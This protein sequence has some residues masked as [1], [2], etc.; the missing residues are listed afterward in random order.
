MI[1]NSKTLTFLLLLS[2]L[3]LSPVNPFAAAQ[4]TAQSAT[5]MPQAVTGGLLDLNYT[6]DNRPDTRAYSGKK[7]YVGMSF[8][9]DLGNEQ[10]VI[11]VSQDHGRWPTHHPGAY[12]VE[13]ARNEDGPWMLAFEGAGQRGDSRAK[14][15][16][17]RAR[18]IRVT[19]TSNRTPYNEEWSI[20]ELRGGIDPG[21][22]AREIP[23]PPGRN[24]DRNPDPVTPPSRVRELGNTRDAFDN[25]A[26][27]YASSGTGDYVG[28]V[29]NFDLG[30][31][32]ELSRVVQIHGERRDDFPAE[33]KIEVSRAKDESR[34]REVF[35]GAGSLRRTVATFEPVVTRYVRL[36]ALRKRD[37]GNWWS[38]AELRTNR[39]RDVVD[40][41]EDDG[42]VARQI[43]SIT[44]NGIG[45]IVAVLDDN[46]T[47]RATTTSPRYEGSWINIDLGGS[48]TVSRIVQVHEP[49]EGAFPGRYKVEVSEDGNR[50]R[51]A[52]EGAG[53]PG[54]SIAEFAPLRARYIR[55]VAIDNRNNR[56][57]WTLYKLK[58]RG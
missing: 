32:Y 8:T 17:I 45:N 26:N 21:Q 40:R 57:L 43:R 52:F 39:D 48:Y 2:G 20:A 5:V 13:V 31:E 53:Q 47:S 18:F 27:S 46:N 28:M 7:D 37:T 10:N 56:Q 3:F 25:N 14:F 44:A 58:V 24:P 49:D 23:R 38:I 15:P 12:R 16:A 19:A 50:W 35:R 9:I 22:T 51:S 11:G 36:T 42:L 30:G 6:T 1:K 33:Y 54:R 34:F 29:F 55:I 41:D 4:Q